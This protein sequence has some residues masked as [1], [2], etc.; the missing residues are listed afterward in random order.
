ME[1]AIEAED[2][3]VPQVLLNFDFAPNLL[4]EFVLD[5]FGFIDG[6]EGEDIF[7]WRF[8][9][10]HIDVSKFAFTQ[11][12]ADVEVVQVPMSCRIFPGW[13]GRILGLITCLRNGGDILGDAGVQSKLFCG[14]AVNFRSSLVIV[15]L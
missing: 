3:G 7:R 14:L 6:L 12:P 1:V 4:F 10:H 8:C 15:N 13:G 9:A 2:I 5:D 11:W